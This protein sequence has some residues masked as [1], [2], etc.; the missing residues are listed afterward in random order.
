MPELFTLTPVEEA[1]QKLFSHLDAGSAAPGRPESGGPSDNSAPLDSASR[2]PGLVETVPTEKALGRFLAEPVTSPESLPSFSKS[3]MDGYAV[4]AADTFG[5]SES[6]PAYLKLTGEAK[7]GATPHLSVGK[8]EAV[9]IHTGGMLPEGADAVV[10]IEHTQKSGEGEIEVLRPAA[11]GENVIQVGEDVG[12]GSELFPAGHRL[13]PQDIGGLTAL[14]ITRVAAALPPRVAILS[15]GD[16]LV[17]PGEIPEPGQVR[18]IN[19]Y[20]ISGIVTRAGGLPVPL[21]IYPD[22]YDTIFTAADKAVTTSGSGLTAARGKG[23]AEDS[24]RADEGGADI[25]VITAGSSVSVR[26]LTVRIINGLGEPGVLVHG[27]AVKPGK[28]TIL[29]MCRGRPVLGLPGNPVSAMITAQLF[30]IPLIR[31]LL[32]VPLSGVPAARDSVVSAVLSKNIRSAPGKEEY[33]PVRLTGGSPW[34]AEPIFGKSNLIYT[35]VRADGLVKI[36]IDSNG[37]HKGEEADVF[38]FM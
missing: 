22:N 24:G 23:S 16:E 25:L 31:H 28:P 32:G 11:E 30:L 7:M 21:G 15:T 29:G 10:M 1:L 35:L 9:V 18:D 5:A 14:G 34:A 38:L 6:L 37:L 4:R 36:P 26:D 13:R 27:I 33:A 12:E 3:T 8:G 2:P 17:S 20:T 19:S